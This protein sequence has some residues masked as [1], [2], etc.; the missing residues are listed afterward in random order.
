LW[1]IGISL[2]VG[3][4]FLGWWAVFY[5]V[6]MYVTG[7]YALLYSTAIRKSRERNNLRKTV[8]ENLV[9]L[10]E[11]TQERE[12]IITVLSACQKDYVAYKN[13]QLSEPVLN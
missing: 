5:P 7:L 3:Y 12:A 2:V 11:L 9:L 4:G 13:E 10:A 8:K 1:Y 6:L